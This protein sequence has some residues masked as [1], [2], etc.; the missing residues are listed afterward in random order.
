MSEQCYAFG[1]FVFDLHR[2]ILL[3]GGS[4]VAIG[5]KGAR[6][7]E[8]MLVAGGRAV[9]KSALIEAAWQSENV[10]ESNLAVQIAALRKCLGRSKSGVEWIATV[11]RVGYQFVNHDEAK[12]TPSSQAIVDR[13]S[14]A[15]F[16]FVNMSGDP[17]REYFSDGMAED[18]ITELSRFQTLF[19]IARNSSF[20][21]RGQNVDVVRAGLQLGVQY[22]VEGSIRQAGNLIRITAQLIETG[23]GHHVWAERF[24]VEQEELFAVQDQVVR[25]IV[26]TL[27]GRLHASAASHVKRKVPA[28]LSAYE[29]VLRGNALPFDEPEAADEARRFFRKAIELDPGYARAYALLADLTYVE[30]WSD[31]S[32]SN[33]GLEQAFALAKKAVALDETDYT[34]Q[35]VLGWALMFRHAHE[36]AEQHHLKAFELNRNRA[37]VLAGLGTVYAYQGKPAEGLKYFERAKLVDPFFEPAWYRR[38]LGVAH[39]AALNYDDSVAVFIRSSTPHF[40]G[41][42]YVAACHALSGRGE[43]AKRSAAEVLCLKPDFSLHLFAAKE[44]YKLSPDRAR[45]IEGLRQAGLPE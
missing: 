27:V 40:W 19:V 22:I 38:V 1:P 33:D 20:A 29:Y 36:Q 12:E 10:E 21:F 16:P 30:W 26:G 43:D 4:P 15:V 18:I 9:S 32:G 6:L 8:A 13:S 14:I 35:G 39:F 42:A 7:L 3:K 25:T 28:S 41:F 45:L 44:P 31:M 2:R 11:H 37:S 24:D 34:C 5:Q 17:E 23:S